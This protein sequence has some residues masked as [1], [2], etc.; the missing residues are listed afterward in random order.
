M[1]IYTTNRNSVCSVVSNTV[2]WI[3]IDSGGLSQATAVLYATSTARFIEVLGGN[4]VS[5]QQYAQLSQEDGH[6]ATMRASTRPATVKIAL[7]GL[8]QAFTYARQVTKSFPAIFAAT[9][10]TELS[11]GCVVSD[12]TS[13]ESATK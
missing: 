2:V 5:L 9:L 1:R 7:C 6:L 3:T 4:V 13:C 11:S 12:P 10:K 8:K